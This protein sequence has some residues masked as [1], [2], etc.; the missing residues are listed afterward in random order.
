M[1]MSY[2]KKYTSRCWGLTQCNFMVSNLVA[3]N[4]K[5][6]DRLKIQTLMHEETSNVALKTKLSFAQL[7]FVFDTIFGVF[8]FALSRCKNICNSTQP[9]RTLIALCRCVYPVSYKKLFSQLCKADVYAIY[10]RYIPADCCL[11]RL[12]YC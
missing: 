1:T 7:S 4:C 8:P 10:D 2:I 9:N 6:L 5:C 3:R 12:S 11:L